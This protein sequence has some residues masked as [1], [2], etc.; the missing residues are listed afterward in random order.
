MMPAPLILSLPPPFMMM[1]PPMKP[2][3]KQPMKLAADEADA[4]VKMEAGLFP[5][6]RNS[7][8]QGS[9]IQSK[10]RVEGKGVL[11]NAGSWTML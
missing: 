6:T 5:A 10:G 9:I 2:A 1:K 8:Q 4:E 3:T 11:L 7:K